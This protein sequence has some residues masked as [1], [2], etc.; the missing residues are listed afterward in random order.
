[1]IKVFCSDCEYCEAGNRG[2]T[3]AKCQ[4]PNNMVDINWY[5]VVAR[6]TCAFLNKNNECTWFSEKRISD[7][8]NIE[9]D[10][11]YGADFR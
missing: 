10:D 9:D 8:N 6:D 2:N 5:N 7:S 3:I 4:H 1:M 11:E